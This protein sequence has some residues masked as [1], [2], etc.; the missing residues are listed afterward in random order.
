MLHTAFCVFVWMLGQYGRKIQAIVGPKQN[1]TES[2]APNKSVGIDDF[3]L[4]PEKH[5]IASWKGCSN[6]GR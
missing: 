1:A 5:V 4:S 2:R 3:A 6:V